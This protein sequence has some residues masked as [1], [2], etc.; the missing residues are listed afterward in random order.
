MFNS[1]VKMV[2]EE[3]Q[4]LIVS[5]REPVPQDL[6][7]STDINRLISSYLRE[8]RERKREREKETVK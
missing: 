6:F 7:E 8:E 2:N 3:L 4:S 1:L 5:C